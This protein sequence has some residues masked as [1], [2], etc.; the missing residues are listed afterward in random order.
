M[1][2]VMD[3]Q[4]NLTRHK[5]SVVWNIFADCKAYMYFRFF[6]AF[7]FKFRRTFIRSMCQLLWGKTKKKGGPKVSTS[8]IPK[9]E[10]EKMKHSHK[11]KFKNNEIKNILSTQHT[12]L[13]S[14]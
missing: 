13:D 4:N 8:Q 12:L 1:G 6:Q 2:Q 7:V 3:D 14:T 9:F 11:K 10:K 5:E